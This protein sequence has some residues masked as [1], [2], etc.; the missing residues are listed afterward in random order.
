MKSPHLLAAIDLGSNSFHLQ[1]ARV[2]G[3]QLY[4]LDAHKESVRLAGGLTS[5][6]MLDAASQRRALDCLARMGE[7]L[8]GMPLESVRAVG[9]NTLRVAR[10]AEDFLVRARATLGFDI[11]VVAGREE[12]RLIYLGVSHS[13]AH[14]TAPRLVVDI[15]GGSTECIIGRGYTPSERESTRIGCVVYS[16]RFFPRGTVTKVAMKEARL[17]AEVALGPVAA[18]F[19]RGQWRR[20]FGVASGRWRLALLVRL[21]LWARSCYRTV[22][23]MARLRVPGSSGCAPA[24]LRRATLVDWIFQASSRIVNRLLRVGWLSWLAFSMRLILRP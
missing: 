19:R 17:A 5:S 2:E 14:D 4:Y 18:Q 10:N 15:G 22:S 13:L 1:V 9:T 12:A 6:G 16:N 23:P 20:S 8:R 11:E 21:G 3:D 7:R 24:W